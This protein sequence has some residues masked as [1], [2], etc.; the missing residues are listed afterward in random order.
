MVFAKPLRDRVRAG[1]ITSSVRIWQRLRVKPG[2][3]YA[4]FP[5]WIVVESIEEIGLEDITEAL[6]RESGF[7]T[8]ESLL[9]TA[10]H[11]PGERVFLVRFRVEG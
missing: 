9:A 4:L 3:R 11:G 8:V 10:R 2:G 7:E 5:G 6:A 1:E